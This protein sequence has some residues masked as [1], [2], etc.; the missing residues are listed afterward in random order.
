MLSKKLFVTASLFFA[1]ASAHVAAWHDG[2][3]C[4]NGTS[5]SD[6]TNTYEIVTPLYK[7]SKKDWWFHGVN[8]CNKYPPAPGKFLELPAGGD[9]T[10]EHATN[11]GKTSLSFNGKFANQWMDGGNHP[12]NWN[13]PGCINNPNIHTANEQN[14]AGTA[15]AISYQSD[16]N[17][18]TPEN[19]VVF[20]VRYHTPW[21]RVTSYSVPAAL[22][23]CPEG[24][25]HCAWGWIP[26]GCGE[27][28]MYHQAFRCKVTNAKSTVPVGQ[29]KPPVWC[30]DDP[31]KCTKG[32]KQM[33]YWNQ[34]EGN[35][36]E[37]KGLDLS[38]QPRSPAYNQKCGFPDGAQNDIFQGSPASAPAPKQDAAPAP[39]PKSDPAPAPKANPPPV[40]SGNANNAPSPKA[41]TSGN[42]PVPPQPAAP[43]PKA[44]LTNGPNPANAPPPKSAPPTVNPPVPAKPPVATPASEP[45]AV[46]APASAKPPR[47]CRPRTKRSSSKRMHY[48]R[49]HRRS[50][51]NTW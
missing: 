46:V 23:A 18:V 33:L 51:S 49:H 26:N 13:E 34:L 19:L 7:M 1:T 20:S 16:I 42:P 37:V 47:V 32:P 40:N 15:F 48:A 9:F 4:R 21:K 38:G 28:N 17:N 45:A 29:G 14:A 8:G 36:I 39:S 6:D 3:Y 35:N 22:P 12:D 44:D 24:G 27:P 11:R 25:C 5:G 30:E 41:P 10:I 50:S 43:S 31:S 2:M